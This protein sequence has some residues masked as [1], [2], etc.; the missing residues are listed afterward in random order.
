MSERTSYAPGTPSWVDLSSPDTDASV[1]FYGTLFGWSAGE[2]APPEAGGYR[3]FE[4]GGKRVAGLGPTMAEGQPP[5][6]LTYVTVDDADAAAER[7]TA[8]GGQVVLAPMDVMTVGRM[9][10]FTDTVGAHFA[11][12]QPKE[13]IGAEVVNEPVSLSWN[14]LGTRDADSPQAFYKQVFGWDCDP[15]EMPDGRTYCTWM[16][17]GDIVGGMFE[18]PDEIPAEIP[19]HWMA[20]FAVADCDATVAKA[21]ELGGA[22]QMQ[23]I[24]IPPGRF[25]VLTD[26]QGAA[27]SVIALAEQPE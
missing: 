13:H 18:M 20:Y 7:V 22:V 6:W 14:E 19:P 2:P 16:L 15:Q 27:F 8:A 5:A 1:E 3:I 10:I 23:P 17:N 4:Q 25:A 12:W 9:A 26:P 24:D 11:V 21:Q